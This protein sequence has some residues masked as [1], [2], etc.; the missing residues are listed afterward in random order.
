MSSHLL[1]WSICLSRSLMSPMAT[2]SRHRGDERS[3]EREQPAREHRTEPLHV[4]PS[5]NL[6]CRQSPLCSCLPLDSNTSSQWA[7]HTS[8]QGQGFGGRRPVNTGGMTHLKSDKLLT[9]HLSDV[10]SVPM[11]TG[12]AISFSPVEKNKAGFRGS[13]LLRQYQCCATTHKTN[14]KQQN[15]TDQA[16]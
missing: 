13:F 11:R 9:N 2:T 6:Y 10:L 4:T 14:S 7:T 3:R 16:A 1:S 5:S 8:D 15:K 12:N